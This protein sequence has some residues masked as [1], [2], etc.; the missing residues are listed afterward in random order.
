MWVNPSLTM[1]IK[2]YDSDIKISRINKHIF[3]SDVRNDCA[4]SNP[5]ILIKKLSH[6]DIFSFLMQKA[7][8]VNY[9]IQFKKIE[10]EFINK[11]HRNQ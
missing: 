5:N 9:T 11:H 10:N 8:G 7:Y 2:G 3:D 1:Y 4:K 6:N